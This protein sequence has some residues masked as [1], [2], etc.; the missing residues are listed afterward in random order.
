MPKGH[1]QIVQGT[2]DFHN[3][4][5]KADLGVSQHIFDNP[6]ALDPANAVFDNDA[7]RGEKPI[8]KLVGQ[9]QWLAGRLLLG[10]LN[11]HSRRRIPLKP[12][13]LRQAGSRWIGDLF[14][15]GHLLIVGLAHRCRTQI[16]DPMRHTV[17]QD[18][19]FVGMRL[20]FPL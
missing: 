5:R 4:I 13:V 1:A 8:E 19:V 7:Y 10:L 12:S 14:G 20:F 6:A 17:G 11:P 15:I 16:E 3:P 18:Q 9:V 2:G